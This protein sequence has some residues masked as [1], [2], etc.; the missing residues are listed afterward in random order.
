MFHVVCH[1]CTFEHMGL[2]ETVARN[3]ATQH[4]TETDHGVEYAEVA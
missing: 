1:D 4:A 2:S 3:K